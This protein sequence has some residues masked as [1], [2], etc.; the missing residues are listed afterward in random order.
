MFSP[1]TR[2]FS[3]SSASARVEPMKPAAPVT[4]QW[5][6]WARRCC[7]TSLNLFT[8][9]TFKTF[10][11]LPGA[12]PDRTTA[13]LQAP[14]RETEGLDRLRVELRFDVDEAAA[15]CQLAGN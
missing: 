1:V 13:C 3:F 15:W 10:F 9:F 7:W 12:P 14:D 5:Y 2:W 4:S 6:W 11:L 8:E